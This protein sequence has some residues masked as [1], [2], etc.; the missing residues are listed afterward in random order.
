MKPIFIYSD[1]FLNAVSWF[2]SVGGISLFPVVIL[3][4]KYKNIVNAYT[5]IRA[6]TIRNHETIHFKQQ[7]ETLVI[8]FYIIYILEF[9]VKLAIYRNVKQAYK[10]ISFEREAYLNEGNFT[11]IKHRKKYNWINLIIIKK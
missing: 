2:F 8:L 3:R 10:N 7:V 9:T 6:K 1:R 5:Y 4:E 11:Y